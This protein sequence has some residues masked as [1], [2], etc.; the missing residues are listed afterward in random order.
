M[1]NLIDPSTS[2]PNNPNIAV[3]MDVENINNIKSLQDLMAE[4]EKHGD[5]TVKKAVG[6]WHRSINIVRQGIV[7]L[8]FDLVHQ[9]NLAPGHNSSDTRIV[10][11]TLEIL[12]NPDI[13]VET[14][15]FVSSDQDFLPLYDRLR[16]LG[17]SVIVAGDVTGNCL[18]LERH[19]DTFIPIEDAQEAEIR[20][21]YERT[22]SEPKHQSV[23]VAPHRMNKQRRT[24]V[25]H[26]IIRAMKACMNEKGITT[27]TD[28]YRNMRRL[29]PSFS[30]KKLG[31]A[32]FDRLL[33]SFSDI[34]AV[35]GR[36][37]AN[38]S[39]KL[40]PGLLRQI[41]ERS[42]RNGTAI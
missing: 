24:S 11:E 41:N 13:D 12:H 39:I 29:D 27:A 20:A 25:E 15:A 36:R 34:L 23:K 5:L 37:S 9:K 14:F 16:E 26:L 7:E 32:R 17:K 38:I 3:L 2:M 31:Y 40:K 21:I 33:K 8:G 1:N 28:L 19:S 18:R 6:D 30:V 35:R 22:H 4:L 10:I 42:R